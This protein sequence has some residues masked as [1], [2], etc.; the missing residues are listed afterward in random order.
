MHL[1]VGLLLAAPLLGACGFD[2]QTDQVNAIAPGTNDRTGQVDVLGAVIVAAEPNRGVFA[3]TLVNNSVSDPDALESF[4]ATTEVQASPL[5]APIDIDR[6]G[7][8]NL[9]DTGGIPANGQFE[10][11]AFVTVQLTFESGQVSIVN[12]VPVVLPCRQ[13]SPE[14]IPELDLAV[15]EDS[16]TSEEAEGE[17]T[18]RYSCDTATP[19]DPHA[20]GGE[21][22]ET[23]QEPV[24]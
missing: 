20:E 6:S 3:A 17:A 2:Y 9:F 22:T 12:D 7:A 4:D 14:A 10:P 19:I 24:E 8:V 21:G 13:Y 23:G 18:G 11:G 16:G 15:A 5:D 1:A